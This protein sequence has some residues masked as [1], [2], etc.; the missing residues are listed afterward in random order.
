[1]RAESIKITPYAMLSR[2]RAGIRGRTLIVNFPGSPSAAVENLNVI[3]PILQ[4]AVE[5]LSD[6]PGA[7]AGHKFIGLKE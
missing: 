4:H 5:L 1:M 7:E 3:L 6:S 2:A